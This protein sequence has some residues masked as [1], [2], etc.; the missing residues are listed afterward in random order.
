MGNV[1]LAWSG[2]L[3]APGLDEF[4][5]LGKFH[6]A[7]VGTAAVSLGDENVAVRS[8]HNRGRRIELVRTASCHAGLAERH[9]ELAV[10]TELQHLLAFAAA[11]NAVRHPDI[12]RAVDMETMR[13][14]KQSFAEALYQLAGG[15]EFE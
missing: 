6:D 1:E 11:I 14:D 8:G 13:K 12:A 15:I 7:G 2:T 5:V 4:A 9:Q 3:L 10:G